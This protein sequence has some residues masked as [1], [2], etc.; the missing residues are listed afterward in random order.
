MFSRWIAARMTYQTLKTAKRR[1]DDA[2]E[3]TCNL[4]GELLHALNSG[5]PAPLWTYDEAR[6]FIEWNAFG[7]HAHFAIPQKPAS[8]RKEGVDKTT[9]AVA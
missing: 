8:S 4:A 3:E 2:L 7:E 9:K 1:Y 6:D 5:Y